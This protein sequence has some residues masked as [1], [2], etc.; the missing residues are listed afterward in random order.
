[1]LRDLLVSVQLNEHNVASPAA[2]FKDGFILVKLFDGR[3]P[4]EYYLYVFVLGYFLGLFIL[5][6]DCSPSSF[7]IIPPKFLLP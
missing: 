4:P 3:I 6:S 2:G 1:M 7:L 5:K